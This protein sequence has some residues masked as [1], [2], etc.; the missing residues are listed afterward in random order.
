[1]FFHF[2]CFNVSDNKCH[3]QKWRALFFTC[4]KLVVCVLACVDAIAPIRWSKLYRGASTEEGVQ[5]F[6]TLWYI[7]RHDQTGI[8]IWNFVFIHSF[9]SFHLQE[10]YK[11][12][13]KKNVQNPIIISNNYIIT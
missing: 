13:F 12:L 9:I 7:A 5:T 11:Y 6:F 10:K 8:L 2:L 1:M 4:I 3:K